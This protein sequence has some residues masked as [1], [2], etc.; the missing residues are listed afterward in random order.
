M[1]LRDLTEQEL[2]EIRGYCDE[3]F[4]TFIVR[5]MHGS[6]SDLAIW[7]ASYSACLKRIL[8]KNEKET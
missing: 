4:Y 1:T 5:P 2:D 3:D 6:P 7:R 8:Q